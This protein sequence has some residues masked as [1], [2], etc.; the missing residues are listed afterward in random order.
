MAE[1]PKPTIQ[2]FTCEF[3]DVFDT[4]LWSVNRLYD[5]ADHEIRRV[6]EHPG[7]SPEVQA[8]GRALADRVAKLLEEIEAVHDALWDFLHDADFQDV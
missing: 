6:A 3:L 4:H 5:G 7:Q 2:M 1:I 8:D